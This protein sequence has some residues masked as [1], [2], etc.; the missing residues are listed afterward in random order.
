MSSIKHPSSYRDPSGFLYYHN[1]SLYRQV[2]KSYQE[3]FEQF[4]SGALYQHLVNQQLLISHQQINVNYLDD[5]DWYQTIQPELVPFISYPYEWCFDMLKDAALTTLLVAQESMVYNMM[6][7]DA[8]AYNV[9]WHKGKMIFI[10]SLSFEK[11]DDT[12]PW[13]AYRQFCEHFLAPLAL[14][15]YRKWPLQNLWLAYPDGFPLPLTK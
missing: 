8:S 3:H 9:Q 11:Y 2:N 1:N 10:D 13:I 5:T 7:K 6:L 15:H 12:K 4:I 14:M